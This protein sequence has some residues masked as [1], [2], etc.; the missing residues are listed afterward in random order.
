MSTETPAEKAENSA[1]T[2]TQ[3]ELNEIVRDRLSR[4]AKKFEDYDDLKSKVQS[5]EAS[6][7]TSETEL[8]DLKAQVASLSAKA[9]ATER[10]A[11]VSRVARDHGITDSEDIALF[12]TGTDE[13]SLVRQAS[14]L[15]ARNAA[16][17][18]AAKAAEAEAQRTNA[19]VS[20]EGSTPSAPA[21]SGSD[22]AFALA[23]AEALG[24]AGQ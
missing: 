16:D 2:F 22:D 4:Q 9:A 6:L 7:S 5:Y 21:G 17:T 3:D 1:K 20:T 14:R 23:I 24:Q 8:S 12:L 18:E 11:L 13:D 10:E 19:H 15:S